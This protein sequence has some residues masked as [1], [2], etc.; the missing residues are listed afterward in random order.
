MFLQGKSF[1]EKTAGR[2]SRVIAVDHTW[3]GSFSILFVLQR[4]TA[5]EFN[6]YEG[7]GPV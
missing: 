2:I 5:R 3:K 7:R 6:G 1:T 4:F